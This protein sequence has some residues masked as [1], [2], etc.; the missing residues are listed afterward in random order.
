MKNLWVFYLIVVLI[1]SMLTG[2]DLLSAPLSYIQLEQFKA[3]PADVQEKLKEQ[4]LGEQSGDTPVQAVVE[5][6]V[7]SQ[8]VSP[9][10]SDQAE[11]LQVTVI[12]AADGDVPTSSTLEDQYR[13]KYQSDLAG[14]LAQFGY[15]L[16]AHSSGQVLQNVVPGPDYIVVPGDQVRIR[17][18]GASVDVQ[19]VSQVDADGTINVPQIGV[20]SVAGEQLGSL[21]SR[22]K[23]EA[24]KYMQGINVSVALEKLHSVEVYVIGEVSNPG[25]HVVPAFSTL[26]KGLQAAGG[27]NKSGSLRSVSLYRGDSL[28]S[29]FDLYDLILS[30]NRGGDQILRDQDVIFVP[31]IGSTVAIAGA[32]HQ[33]GIFEILHEKSV[34]QILDFAGGTLPNA[35]SQSLYI[36]R[37]DAN[38]DFQ[39][40]DLRSHQQD[41]LSRN[42]ILSGDLLEIPYAPVAPA[43][44]VILEGHVKAPQTFAYSPGLRLSDV[45]RGVDTLK[46]EALTEYALLHRYNKQSTRYEMEKFPLGQVLSGDFDQELQP[47]DRIEI[48][49][50]SELGIKETVAISGAVWR[51]DTYDFLPGMTVADLLALAGGVKDHEY[52]QGNAYLYR[53]DPASLQ[54]TIQRFDL[55]LVLK[56]ENAISLQAFDKVELLSRTNYNFDDPVRIEGA[57]RKSGEYVWRKSMTVRDLI[58]MAGGETFGAQPG[59]VEVSRVTIQGGESTTTHLTVDLQQQSGFLLQPYDYVRMPIAKDATTIAKVQITGEVLYPGTYSV[60]EGEH[61]SDVLRRAGGFTDQAYYYGARFTSEKSRQIQQ[62][63]IDKMVA[64]LQ[65]QLRRETAAAGE[66][67]LSGDAVEAARLQQD[68]AGRLLTELE[69]VRAD[70]RVSMRLGPLSEFAGSMH[71]FVIRDG[72]SLFVPQRPGF[73]SVVGSVYTPNSFVYQPGMTIGN[74]LEMSGG[75][76]KEADEDYIYVQRANGEVLSAQQSGMFSSFYGQ[77]LMPGDTLVV[78]EDFERIPALRLVKDL[79][80]IVFRIAT[81]AGIAFAI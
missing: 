19:Y 66:I 24:L 44:A 46:P 35:Y 21:E 37:Y 80:E 75:P 43:S 48:L 15:N 51:P 25:L 36:K 26:F 45:I 10:D 7:V 79:T 50:R 65:M 63:S 47:Y 74:Y 39:V 52:M 77:E 59:R 40:V 68:A 18:W 4:Y 67:A 54:Y 20:I 9:A 61:L 38:N 76:T 73:V 31:R 71:D 13:K 33:P 28:V 60:K 23:D 32:V 56:N 11:D 53:Y 64:R 70:G 81:S 42:V 3:L 62:A 30:G 69:K 55:P 72:D 41:V 5:E 6:E 22:I 14:S 29:S 78:M 57:V 58:D 17:L 49:S 16:F 2:S 1:L 8:T 12:E 34:A 27:I